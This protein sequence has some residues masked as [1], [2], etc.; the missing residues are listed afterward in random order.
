MPDGKKH[1]HPFTDLLDWGLHPFP[2]DVEK[3]VV[4]IHRLNPQ[5]LWEFASDAFGWER[6]EHLRNARKRLRRRLDELQRR[7][8]AP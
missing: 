2:E 4:E 1:D 7:A 6:G 8:E 5:A 3:L